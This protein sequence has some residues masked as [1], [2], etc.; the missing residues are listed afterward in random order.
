MERSPVR[1]DAYFPYPGWK[2]ILIPVVVIPPRLEGNSNLSSCY[3]T[4]V[5]T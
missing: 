4:K 2:V 5:G 1:S 3:T